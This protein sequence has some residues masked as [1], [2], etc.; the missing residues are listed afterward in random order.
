MR[1]HTKRKVRLKAWPP[2]FLFESE[3]FLSDDRRP[4]LPPRPV[5]HLWLGRLVKA[6][7]ALTAY[8]LS[9]LLWWIVEGTVASLNPLVWLGLG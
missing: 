7:Q 4:E 8:A 5:R 6:I 9:C 1:Q 2:D 3:K